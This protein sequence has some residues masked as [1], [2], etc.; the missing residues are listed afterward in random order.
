[1]VAKNVV[2]EGVGARKLIYHARSFA[3]M[4]EDAFKFFTLVKY[5]F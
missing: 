3:N 5:G 1:M 2:L 4:E